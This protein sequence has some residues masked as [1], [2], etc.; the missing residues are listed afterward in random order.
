MG[1]AGAAL[2]VTAPVRS[3]RVG[4]DASAGVNVFDLNGKRAVRPAFSAAL[5]ALWGF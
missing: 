4:V 2:L 1:S 3:V 5:L